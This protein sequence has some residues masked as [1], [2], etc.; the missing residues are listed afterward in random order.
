MTLTG[1][2]KV[3][4]RLRRKASPRR[5]RRAYARTV[6]LKIAPPLTP[7]LLRSDPATA[8]AIGD[9]VPYVMVKAAKGA[10]GYEKSEDPICCFLLMCLKIEQTCWRTTSPSIRNIISSISC[11]RCRQR[12]RQLTHQPLMRIFEPIMN[13][14]QSLLAVGGGLTSRNLTGRSHEVNFSRHPDGT[15]F[16]PPFVAV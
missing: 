9:R 4:R 10:K 8:P 2:L 14:P 5:P 3:R 16:P 12:R 1:P 7:P 13:H 6:F 15:S 11:R